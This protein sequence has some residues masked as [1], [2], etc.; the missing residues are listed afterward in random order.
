MMALLL[1]LLALT[2]ASPRRSKLHQSGLSSQS[3]RVGRALRQW[4]MCKCWRP[5]I[6]KKLCSPIT[7]VSCFP[8][9][10]SADLYSYP[11][12]AQRHGRGSMQIA[13]I[14]ISSFGVS[15]MTP[16]GTKVFFYFGV[17]R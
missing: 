12:S 16:F 1:L 11:G 9:V 14:L 7:T 2:R 17:F 6:Q 15:L 5:N 3:G 4:R 8:T 10:T 13:S